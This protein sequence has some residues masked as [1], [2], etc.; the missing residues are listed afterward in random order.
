MHSLQ[1]TGNRI[2]VSGNYLIEY[3]HSDT[4]IEVTS[5]R[6]GRTVQSTPRTD[7]DDNIDSE[8]DEAPARPDP[9]I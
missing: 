1:I 2:F 3:S 6:H 8:L 9:E 5:I 7:M 4:R